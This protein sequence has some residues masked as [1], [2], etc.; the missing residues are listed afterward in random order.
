VLSRSPLRGLPVIQGS[1]ERRGRG[2]APLVSLA[3]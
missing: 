1:H 3:D 2:Y